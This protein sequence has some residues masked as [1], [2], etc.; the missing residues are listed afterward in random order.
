MTDT[1]STP[2]LAA[3]CGKGGVGK[4][5]LSA[6][7]TKVLT[8]DPNRKVLAIDADPAVGLAV[9]L[10]LQVRRTVDD[11]RTDLIGRLKSGYREDQREVLAQ[12]D[13]EIFEALEECENLA[14]LAIGR[15]EQEGC[16]C[17]V[18]DLLKG[19]IREIASGFDF[20]II[21]GEAGIEQVNRRVMEMVTHL[22]LVT[23]TSAK[24]RFVAESIERVSRRT[25]ALSTVGLI[26]NRVREE[27]EVETIRRAT[28]L[29]I[30]GWIPEDET[31]YRFDREGRSFLD[32]E[33]SQALP[34][35][36]KAVR[37]F[38][39]IRV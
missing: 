21:D 12:L 29:P 9:S 19:I 27:S 1:K 20:V 33:D 3:I 34:A 13:Y 11:I 35:V 37:G 28:D 6:L 25:A 24:G 7:L 36:Q 2:T 5:C 30:M 8:A 14:F 17:Q 26:I 4:T 15:P 23:D 38:L 22:L 18:N 16:Y 31:V 39:K 32:L 10:G